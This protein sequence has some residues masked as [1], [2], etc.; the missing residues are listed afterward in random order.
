MRELPLATCEY[1][2]FAWI[3]QA[4]ATQ[5]RR[6][7]KPGQRFNG[8]ASASS[9]VCTKR[10]YSSTREREPEV[11]PLK[12]HVKV[13]LI[14]SAVVIAIFS[15]VAY[16]YNRATIN[17]EHNQ[18]KERALQLA[19]Y[20]ADRVAAQG[21]RSPGPSGE[22]QA[23]LLQG[24]GFELS[25]Y[26]IYEFRNDER[27][28][29][30]AVTYQTGPQSSGHQRDLPPETIAELANRGFPTPEVTIAK[31]GH[32]AVWA[33]APIIVRSRLQEGVI[34]AVGILVE[35]SESKSLASRM[36]RQTLG[37][38]GALLLLITLTTYLL[39]KHLVYDPVDT[40]L[41]AMRRA[42]SG[43]LSV[44]VPMRRKDEIG[45]LTER[46]NRMVERLREHAEERI[47]H[48]RQL[49]ERVTD[50]TEEINA[51][52]KQL[53][54]KNVELFAM[55]RQLGELERLATAGQ[56]A[57]QFAH[58]VGTPLNLISG[59]VQLLRAK[60][61]DE[62]TLKRLDTIAAQISRIE[63]IVRGMLDQTRRPT[64]RLEPVD[65]GALLSRL[66]DTI[67]P[68]L[69]AH[70]VDLVASIAPDLPV[71]RADSDQ[72][73]QVFIN[74]VNNSLDVMPTGGQISVSA[75]SD[76]RE[77]V[78][79]FSDTG[80]GIAERDMAHIFE[81]LFTTKERGR[82]SGL[83]LAVSQQ[84]VHEHGGRIDVASEAGQ[85]ATFT[86]SLPIPSPTL[87]LAPAEPLDAL[88]TEN[89]N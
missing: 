46:F 28:N 86:I 75:Q 53:Q 39:F 38:L 10:V 16:V 73:Q 64:A 57:A 13:T 42:E 36:N 25:L 60:E 4:N 55:Q 7:Q 9:S 81:P 41:D 19:T 20:L 45:F 49:E 85:G 34:G 27:G 50:A 43:D 58:E 30:Y 31:E 65:L 6:F 21:M 47:A 66:F 3:I 44:S 23:E 83:G 15:I 12:L 52:N 88:A 59:H 29:L 26:Q 22:S 80:S 82:G 62:R 78:V 68:T 8:N 2:R 61:T 79:A 72:L 11:R 77:V 70:N 48:A 69:A 71:V 54:R 84:I 76:D 5:A 17:L 87:D 40:L 18:Y 24:Y 32:F 37:A 74:L 1:L 51:S 14:V 63:R 67:T 33:L 89:L 56:L 35:V